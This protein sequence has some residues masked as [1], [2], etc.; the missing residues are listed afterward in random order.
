MAIYFFIMKPRQ[1]TPEAISHITVYPETSKFFLKSG[2]GIMTN[3]MAY[4]VLGLI[5]MLMI[6]FISPSEKTLAH[7]DIVMKISS[8]SM[9]LPLAMNFLFN[10]YLSGLKDM[11]RLKRLQ[12]LLN[13]N[14]LIH[15]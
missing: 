3:S 9:I 13:L 14:I 15:S 8:I 1:L 10:P 7:Y 11:S 2:V 5:N 12:Q 4:I 6:E